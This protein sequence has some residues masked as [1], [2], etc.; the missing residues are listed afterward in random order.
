MF[1]QNSLLI[2]S[3]THELNLLD[4]L[5]YSDKRKTLRNAYSDKRKTLR[6]E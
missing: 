1:N 2:A 5:A 6:N 4:I 3:L